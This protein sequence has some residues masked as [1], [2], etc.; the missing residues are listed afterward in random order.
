MTKRAWWKEAIVYQIYPR[1]FKDSNG[2]GIGDLKGIIEKLDY[3]ESL[4]VDA[5]WLNPIFRSPNDDGG[6]DISDYYTI[7]PEFGTMA[8]FDELLKG[9]HQR[10]LKLIMDLV[11]N[12][13]SDEHEWFQK[14]RVSLD[15][16][17]RK[18][19]FWKPGKEGKAPNNWP[20]FFGGSA[21][22]LDEESGEYYLHL[23]SRKQPDLNWEH[24]PL[25]HEVH[26][27][28]KFWLDKGVDGLR[29]DVISAISKRVDFP[30]TDTEDFNETIRR[31]YANGP[32]LQEFIAEA[33][34]KVW[35][36]Y[37]VM[38]VGE[39]PGITPQNALAYLDEKKGLNMIFHFGH[40]FIDQGPGGR[41][42][43]IPWTIREFKKVFKT[44]DDAFANH[45][46]GS[47]FL[48]NHDFPRMVSRWGNDQEYWQESSTLLCTLLLTMRGTPFIF[49][50]DE[51]GMTNMVLSSISES[52][53]IETQTGWREAQKRGLTESQFLK[54]ANYSGRDNARTPMQ[55]DSGKEAGFTNA[56]PWMPVN[57]NYSRLN[58]QLQAGTSQSVLNYFRA[59]TRMRKSHSV[60]AY[61]T[62]NPMDTGEENLFIYLREWQ[63]EKMLIVL[64]FC[65]EVTILPKEVH[66]MLVKRLIGNYPERNSPELRPWEAGVYQL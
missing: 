45:G 1:S 61:G 8:D 40:M 41:F 54:I 2:D 35:N 9:L 50:G 10:K 34:E 13:S 66:A 55:W 37:D 15:N 18:Y 26:Q 43:P 52:R 22:Q 21:W 25:R 12:H 42:D 23:F 59:L 31:Y 49:M 24:P 4:G 46:W 30:D 11:L 7:Q 20:S 33:R 62:Y 65:N 36:H 28:M 63:Q 57:P 6:Y 16:P 19:Y 47:V 14:S 39:G 5:V 56:Q 48:G 44:W 29:L 60:F 64:N 51:I 38:T 53:D 3:I 32:R 27:L 58:V 17:Y